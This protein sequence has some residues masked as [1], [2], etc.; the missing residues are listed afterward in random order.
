MADKVD[1]ED[2]APWPEGLPD[3]FGGA[4]QR[5]PP[6]SYGNDP[7]NWRAA[8]KTPGATVAGGIPPSVVTQP[9]NTVGVGRYS[10]SFTVAATGTAP[11]AYQWTFN[12]NSI[13]GAT[14][15]TLTL[16]NLRLDQAGAYACYVFNGAG[17]VLSS[18]A[19]LTVLTPVTITGQPQNV[20]LR[21][22]TNVSDYG[23]TTNN[24]TF[25][26]TVATQRP[27]RYQWSHNG[28]LLPDGTN[29]SLTVSNVDFD[30]H[31][32]EYVL[33]ATDDLS[34]DVSQS[35]RL[36]V[37][38]SPTII[39]PPP[40]NY[41]VASNGSI[42]ASVVILGNPPPFVYRWNE[43][44]TMRSSATNALRTNYMSY[45]PIT[46]Y[47]PRTWRIIITNEANVAPT[48]FSQFSV[49][50]ALDTDLDGIP[51]DWEA[52]YGFG[53][54]N[55]ADGTIDFDGDGMS[56]RAEYYAGTNP[57]NSASYLRV[58]GPVLGGG[59]ATL[60]VGAV[61]NRTYS[62][63]YCDSL[64]T[65]G[66]SKLGDIQAKSANHVE[67]VTDPGGSTNRFYRVVTPAQ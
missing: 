2:L 51:D 60:T 49:A 9:G 42:S 21:G 13:Y 54:N 1:Y 57:T 61:S 64:G 39:I 66:W 31:E 48:A 5:T 10:A 59:G 30:L 14:G 38:L 26:A 40:T 44:S 18:N 15:P 29:S 43:G 11:L 20:R 23:F 12:S 6:S 63:L 41:L 53:T 50:A 58:D 65:P 3:G 36:T 16:N 4:L 19:Q 45:G 28:N 17:F 24:A 67:S 62:V 55:V 35:A 7:A 47:A 52:A 34:A 33:R 22:S 37:L 46:N 8:V 56:N 27:T 32:G 25:T